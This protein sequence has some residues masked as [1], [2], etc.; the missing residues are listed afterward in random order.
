MSEEHNLPKQ[1]TIAATQIAS[2]LTPQTPGE[3]L[4][5][6]RERQGRTVQQIADEMHLGVYMVEAMESN[7]FTVLGAPVFA[8][9]HLRKYAMLLGVPVER[10]HELYQAVADR[11]RDE[12]PVPLM[13]RSTEPSIPMSPD[14][15]E[16]RAAQLP[17]R[18]TIAVAVGALALIALLAWFFIGRSTPT[19]DAAPDAAEQ[20]VSEALPPPAENISPVPSAPVRI[21]TTEPARAAA[22]TTTPTTSTTPARTT[23]RGKLSLRFAFTQESW[24][25]VYDARGTRLLYDVG[26]P[27]QSRSVEVDPPAQVVIGQANGVAAEVNGR[28]VVVPARRIANQVARFTVGADGNVQ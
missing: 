6:E 21:A 22:A 24:V 20:P 1:E 4:Q 15:K 19:P 16:R 10:V 27:G 11:P 25:E 26:Q 2:A 17:A 7:R 13:H 12:D 23:P 9:G 5:L 8:R 14:S 18:W 28:A 3:W